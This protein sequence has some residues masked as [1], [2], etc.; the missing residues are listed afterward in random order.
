MIVISL[1]SIGFYANFILNNPFI[2]APDWF[3]SAITAL[4]FISLGVN[5]LVTPLILYKI[6]IVYIDIRELNVASVNEAHRNGRPDLSALISILIESGLI[7]FAAQLAQSIMYKFDT[8][9]ISTC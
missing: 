8:G 4:F 1:T 2:R 5:A 9:R 3:F 6:I 7:T